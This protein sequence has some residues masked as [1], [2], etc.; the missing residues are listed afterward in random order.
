MST[1]QERIDSSTNSVLTGKESISNA[2]ISKGVT[3]SGSTFSDLTAGI[4]SISVIEEAPED[5]TLYGR[6]NAGW[7]KVSDEYLSKTNTTAFNP[8]SNYHPATK[9]YVDDNK[10]SGDYEDL[11]NKPT[12]PSQYVLPASTTSVLGGIKV[13]YAGS[14]K[15]YKVQIDS[16]SNAY[17]NVPWTDTTYTDATISSPGLMSASDKSRLDKAVVPTVLNTVSSLTSIP[18]DKYN[19]KFTYSRTSPIAISFASTPEEGAEYIISIYNSTSSNITQPIPNATGW[20]SSAT[21]V[22]C[23]AGKITEVSIRYIFGKYIVRI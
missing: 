4:N 20:Q 12:I 13:G 19:I 17:V 10:F 9:K 5:S 23:P 2:I 1:L 3:P 8:T 18:I 7:S 15:N 16:G 11:T 14:G 21:S 22:T 6:K